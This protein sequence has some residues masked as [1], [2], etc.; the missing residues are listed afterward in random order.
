MFNVLIPSLLT[1]GCSAEKQSP[2]C[3]AENQS[4]DTGMGEEEGSR[5]ET[6]GIVAFLE[7][8]QSAEDLPVAPNI[9]VTEIVHDQSTTTNEFGEYLLL[10]PDEDLIELNVAGPNT[11]PS[12][13]MYN[14]HYEGNDGDPYINTVVQY[15]SLEST[16][17]I[18]VIDIVEP[19][20]DGSSQDITSATLSVENEY[21]FRLP[22]V[23]ENV[24]FNVVP[25]PLQASLTGPDGYICL[26]IPEIEIGTGEVIN[27][28]LYCLQE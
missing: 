2:C 8:F 5:I 9:S 4:S 6:R 23:D 17:S 21:E 15:E 25:G 18:L 28:S 26:P 19:M 7:G 14:P 27:L 11:I 22:A 24:F 10:V 16:R 13:W 3:S 12:R 1:L 20:N